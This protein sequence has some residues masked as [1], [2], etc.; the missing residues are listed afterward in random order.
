M[1]GSQ[2]IDAGAEAMNE[3][4]G[5]GLITISIVV[6]PE[7]QFNA[8]DLMDPILGH[9]GAQGVNPESTEAWLRNY[10]ADASPVPASECGILLWRTH[11]SG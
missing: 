9:L 8:A 7:Y 11:R 1:E 3:K 4:A 2:V 10:G 5:C 6:G